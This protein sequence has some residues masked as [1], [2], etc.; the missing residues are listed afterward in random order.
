MP[1]SVQPKR[2]IF[3]LTEPENLSELPETPLIENS[4]V[5]RMSARKKGLL[6]AVIAGAA[7]APLVAELS[8]SSVARAQSPTISNSAFTAAAILERVAVVS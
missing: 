8:D 7:A 2:Q 3:P 4:F 1:R 5:P 6:V